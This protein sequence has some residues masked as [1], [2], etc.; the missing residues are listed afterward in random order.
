[1]EAVCSAEELVEAAG[2][3]KGRAGQV[4]ASLAS[5][6]GMPLK[7]TTPEPQ[8]YQRLEVGSA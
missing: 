8:L 7:S 1:M 2:E 3:V 6:E 5:E 4:S